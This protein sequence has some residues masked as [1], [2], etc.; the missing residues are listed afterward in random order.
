MQNSKKHTPHI[1]FGLGQVRF[2]RLSMGANFTGG[3][4]H[5]FIEVDRLPRLLAVTGHAGRR[6]V[7]MRRRPACLQANVLVSLSAPRAIAASSERATKVMPPRSTLINRRLTQETRN[8][9]MDSRV[10]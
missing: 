1:L 8:L 7:H 6:Y 3:R 5:P 2:T 4:C 9:L 10:T